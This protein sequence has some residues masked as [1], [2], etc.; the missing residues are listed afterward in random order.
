[1]AEEQRDPL[2]AQAHSHVEERASIHEE[3]SIEEDQTMACDE[4]VDNSMLIGSIT[5]TN[6]EGETS[7]PTYVDYEDDDTT[8]PHAPLAISYE[9]HDTITFDR[10]VDGIHVDDAYDDD[11]MLAPKY[12]EHS[13]SHPTHDTHDDDEGMMVPA[14]DGGVFERSLGDMDP[15]SQESCVEE[16]IMHESHHS[17]ASPS[18]SSDDEE[19]ENT[20]TDDGPDH[21]DVVGQRPL[22]V[23]ELEDRLFVTEDR[24]THVLTRTDGA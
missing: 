12:D 18:A 19:E 24:I 7:C 3:V 6:D 16:D 4:T 2:V 17:M 11:G 9:V 23:R 20:L 15:S 5:S 1:M 13:T 22:A 8:T 21:L 10:H 14:Y